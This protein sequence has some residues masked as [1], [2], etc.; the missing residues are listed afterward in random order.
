MASKSEISWTDATWSPVRG[1]TRVSEGCRFCYSERMAARGLPGLKSP[2]N[3]E[4]FAIMG[5]SGP[6]WTGKVELI[7]SQLNVPFRWRRPRRIFVNSLSDTFHESLSFAQIERIFRVMLS[8]PQ[9]TY[10]LLTKRAS[11]LP[12][13]IETVMYRIYGPYWRFPDFIW[14][15]VS[16]EDQETADERIPWLLEANVSTRF[17]SY[18]PAL[19]PVDFGRLRGNTVNALDGIDFELISGPQIPAIDWII[20]GGESGPKS[21]RFDLEWM[22]ATVQQ[23]KLASVPV[24]N[25]QIGSNPYWA[26]YPLGRAAKHDRKGGDMKEWPEDLRIRQFPEP[27]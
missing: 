27:R 12:E 26:G 5:S 20:I 10:Q 8:A 9:H 19:G 13:V 25:K 17:V 1:C 15:G 11:R 14:V 7:E 16:V 18:E 4:N 2:T 21:R 3:G 24:F 6:R 23:C 22:R